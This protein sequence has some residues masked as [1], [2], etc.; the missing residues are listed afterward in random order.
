M[1]KGLAGGRTNTLGILWSLT[2]PHLSA[3]MAENIS[4]RSHRHGY[5][6]QLVNHLS[7][8]TITLK[9]LNDF[10][11]RGVDAVVM[12]DVNGVLET[13]G[14][15]EVLGEFT[16]AVVVGST[17]WKTSINQIHHDR[18][19]ACR[20]VA[21]HFAASG[22]RRPAILANVG[23]NDRKIQAFL[24]SAAQHSMG[25]TNDS[26]MQVTR[27]PDLSL[28]QNCWRTLEEHFGNGRQFKFDAVFCLNDEGAVATINWLAKRGLRVSDDV[29]VVGFNDNQINGYLN[30][31]LASVDRRDD[32]VA[33]T[34]DEIIFSQLSQSD[35]S[36][37]RRYIPMRFAWRESAGGV[38]GFSISGGLS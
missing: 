34:I 22:R 14:I 5:A 17:P 7:D 21:Q 12:Q 11:R 16:V 15:T 38:E 25:V 2:G 10:K 9:S 32:Q 37:Q 18:L 13:P 36:P 3:S 29:A 35:S 24:E 27:K 1:A 20:Q 28:A 33:A 26:L 23:S 4:L 8:P 30:P 19:P 31:P 6:T